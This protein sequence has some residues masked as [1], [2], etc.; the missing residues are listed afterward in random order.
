M[1]GPQMIVGLELLQHQ[2]WWCLLTTCTIPSRFKCLFSWIQYYDILSWTD[3]STL[4]LLNQNLKA[5]L[6]KEST[7][8]IFELWWSNQVWSAPHYIDIILVGRELSSALPR[9][10][11]T[12]L[13]VNALPFLTHVHPFV[14]QM[15]YPIQTLEGMQFLLQKLAWKKNPQYFLLHGTNVCWGR[16]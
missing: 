6:Q 11:R 15:G 5:K 10:F 13:L 7:L 9:P 3:H 12:S 8:R 1:P 16:L 4:I 14:L 2:P